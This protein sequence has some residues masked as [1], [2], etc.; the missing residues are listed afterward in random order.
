MTKTVSEDANV[1]QV[2]RVGDNLSRAD[3]YAV[4]L[5]PGLAP[6]LRVTGRTVAREQGKNL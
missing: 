5:R 1:V 6:V 4:W 2:L 3:A